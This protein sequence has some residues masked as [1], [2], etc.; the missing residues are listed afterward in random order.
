LLADRVEWPRAFASLA[1]QA[2]EVVRTCGRRIVYAPVALPS[3]RGSQMS[4]F[5]GARGVV[6]EIDPPGDGNSRA[7]VVGERSEA[8]PAPQRRQGR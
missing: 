1:R 8:P 3:G 6:A 7:G 4:A 2:I 5:R